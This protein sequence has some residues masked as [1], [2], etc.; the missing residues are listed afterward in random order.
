MTRMN[1]QRIAGARRFMCDKDQYHRHWWCW[2]L[3]SVA[4]CSVMDV[5]CVT[6][7]NNHRGAVFRDAGAVFGEVGV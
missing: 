3:I 6:G 7:I 4:P 2:R 5:S 1:H